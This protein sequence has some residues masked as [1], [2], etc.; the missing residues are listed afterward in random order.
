ML[1]RARDA[2]LL[3]PGM[4]ALDPAFPDPGSSCAQG[5][6]DHGHPHKVEAGFPRSADQPEGVTAM[7][8]DVKPIR[9]LSRSTYCAAAITGTKSRCRRLA[10]HNGDCRPTLQG[11]AV[12]APPKAVKA[13]KAATRK[14]VKATVSA[15]PTI[16]I[17]GQTFRLVPVT[18]V[19][20][21]PRR[22]VTVV[23]MA[24]EPSRVQAL[25]TK[26][27]RTRGYITSGKPSARL[28]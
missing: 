16:T 12:V 21:S 5:G 18:S 15:E 9:R 19:K 28:A 10:G 3:A 6:T 25:A 17:N 20:A 13:S 24:E 7:L 23:P 27:G 22:K 11:P 2:S 26:H 1:A 4:R 8:Q 14:A